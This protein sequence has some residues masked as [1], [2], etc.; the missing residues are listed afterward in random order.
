[1]E[2]DHRRVTKM[3]QGMEHLL[4]E[5]RLK[6]LGLF[7]LEK[8]RLWADLRAAFQYLKEGYKKEGDRL[9]SSI[10]CDRTRKNWLQTRREE[11]RIGS[12]KKNRQDVKV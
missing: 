3:I 9:F 4:Y 2:H 12:K 7:I 6:E 1:M 8:R 11:I 10:C 5:D